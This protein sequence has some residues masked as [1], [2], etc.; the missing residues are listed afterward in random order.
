MTGPTVATANLLT[1]NPELYEAQ[2][3]DPDHLAAGFVADLVTRFAAP[4]DSEPTAAGVARVASGRTGAAGPAGVG[5]RLLDAG[6]G[7]GRDA[8]HLAGRG[9]TVTGIDTSA[10]M[11]AHARAR[12]P[13]VDFVQADLR[14][15]ALP[16][17]FDVV[18]C[19]DSALLYCHTNAD[20][21]A[22]L[23]RCHTQLAPG[24]LLVTESRNGAFFLGNTE[25][26]DGVR[27]RTVLW[28]GTPY[29]SHTLLW[30]DHAEQLLRRRRTWT[31]PEC[32]DPLVQT[33]AW[34]LLFPMELRH[35]LETTGF[36]VLALF[37]HPG[38]RT[39]PPWRADAALGT[40]LRG[41][42]LH[43]VARRRADRTRPDP[44]PDLP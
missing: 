39:D 21:V 9:W 33:S 12:H 35:L 16:G 27:T 2:F 7:T 44:P 25:L 5:W 38:P 30:I 32:A 10:R 42:R 13:G 15:F 26:L 14:S 37:D 23:E 24:G 28:R 17:R 40:D 34:R 19:L 41:D 36:E 29:T 22:F 18:S 20:L 1:D 6:C 3:P 11:L 4:T 31:W 43:L 8:G